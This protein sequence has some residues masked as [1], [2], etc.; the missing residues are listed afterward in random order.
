MASMWIRPSRRFALYARDAFA[1][2][3]CSTRGLL[4]GSNLTLDHVEPRNRFGGH[5]NANLATCCRS[6]N[7]KKGDRGAHEWLSDEGWDKNAK[8]RVYRRLRR[9][10]K[11][12]VDM[13]LGRLLSTVDRST[14]ETSGGGG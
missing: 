2:I 3:Y 7:S 1:C 5:D 4:D 13:R 6:C 8:E 12:T 9:L 10:P 11:L 14:A